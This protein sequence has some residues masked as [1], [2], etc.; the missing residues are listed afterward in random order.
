[1]KIGI[2][3][4]GLMGASFGRALNKT[5]NHQVYGFDINEQVML[6]AE[7]LSAMDRPLTIKDAKKLDMLVISVYPRDFKAVAEE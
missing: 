5:K 6:K 4:L 3:G 2:V 7:L 1:M